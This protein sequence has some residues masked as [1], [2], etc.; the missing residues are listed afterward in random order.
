MEVHCAMRAAACKL[1]K[2]DGR[3]DIFYSVF[4]FWNSFDF[5][6]TS[7]GVFEGAFKS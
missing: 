2:C 3:A 6:E 7:E 4:G 1:L 5:V